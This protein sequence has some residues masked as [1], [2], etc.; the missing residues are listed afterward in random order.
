MFA[1]RSI[2]GFHVAHA[3]KKR[4][5]RAGV[6][7][8]RTCGE[9]NCHGRVFPKGIIFEATTYIKKYGRRLERHWC[10]KRSPKTLLI[11]MLWLQKGRNYHRTFASK[12]VADVLAVFA[13]WRYYR[14]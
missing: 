5:A 7:S 9:S 6:K 1:I 3:H 8:G 14:M 11:N 12:G 2:I 4:Q 13:T 10:V